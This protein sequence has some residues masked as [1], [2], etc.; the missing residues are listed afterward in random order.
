M[1]LTQIRRRFLTTMSLAGAAGLF[2]AP[3]SLTAEGALETTAL[4]IAK[5]VAI[6]LAP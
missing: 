5:P 1:P 2:G 4:R 6:C 3:P